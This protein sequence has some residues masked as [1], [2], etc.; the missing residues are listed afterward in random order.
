MTIGTYIDTHQHPQ[1]LREQGGLK[2]R[3]RF[4]PLDLNL[5]L[6]LDHSRPIITGLHIP[7][8]PGGPEGAGGLLSFIN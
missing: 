3:G 2:I 7:S 5:D 6:D 4:C 1:E 8:Q